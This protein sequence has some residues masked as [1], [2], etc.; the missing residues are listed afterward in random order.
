MVNDDFCDILFRQGLHIAAKYGISH[1]L[2]IKRSES[3]RNMKTN[4][5]IVV[6]TGDPVRVT[7]GDTVLTAGDPD[8]F[9]YTIKD[10]VGL[11]ARPAGALVKLVKKYQST[12]TISAGEKTVNAGNIMGVMSLGAVKGTRVT[13]KASGEDSD[14]VL[15]ALGEFFRAEL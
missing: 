6:K 15:T 9:V 5:E 8:S 11:H 13:I 7:H 12:V 4:E 1:C 14:E 10:S 2:K 3:D